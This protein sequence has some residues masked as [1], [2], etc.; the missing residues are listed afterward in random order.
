MNVWFHLYIVKYLWSLFGYDNYENW[1]GEQLG[2]S[3]KKHFSLE[4]YFISNIFYRIYLKK[5]FWPHSTG[6]QGQASIPFPFT[7][8]FWQCQVIRELVWS[9]ITIPI[10]STLCN[11]FLLWVLKSYSHWTKIT[12]TGSQVFSGRFQMFSRTQTQ[13][14][15]CFFYDLRR[16]Q[17]ALNCSNPFYSLVFKM[18][19]EVE[20]CFQV[21][22]DGH[23][24]A[25]DVH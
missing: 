7:F 19:S 9:D 2:C 21:F 22:T 25:L 4:Q 20:R 18:C 17:D 23:R 10:Q 16:S 6:P 13:T 12:T 5:I 3:S 1:Y 8:C 11:D 14:H 24:C 15:R